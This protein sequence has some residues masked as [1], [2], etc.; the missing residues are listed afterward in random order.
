MRRSEF[1]SVLKARTLTM[2]ARVAA[3]LIDPL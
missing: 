3:L 1:S 2:T